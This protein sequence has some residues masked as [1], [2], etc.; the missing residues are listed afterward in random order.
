MGERKEGGETEK[1]RGKF[2]EKRATIALPLEGASDDG[3]GDGWRMPD[4]A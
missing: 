3:E 4:V 1:Q 2:L